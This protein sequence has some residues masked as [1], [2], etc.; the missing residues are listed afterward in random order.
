MRRRT[1]VAAPGAL[2]LLAAC[3]LI[4]HAASRNDAATVEDRERRLQEAM[5]DGSWTIVHETEVEGYL[6]SGARGGRGQSALAV[7]EPIGGGRYQLR[8]AVSHGAGVITNNVRIQDTWYDV[9]WF[10]GAVTEYA[11]VSYVVGRESQGPYRYDTSEM[12]VICRPAPANEYSISAAY[13][14]GEGTQ[15]Q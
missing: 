10:G 4:Y 3:L 11:E 14:D 2:I 8:E 9:I 7:F 13:Y 6:L 5:P 12:E 15:Y 1:W